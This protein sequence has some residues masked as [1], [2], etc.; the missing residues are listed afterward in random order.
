MTVGMKHKALP[1]ADLLEDFYDNLQRAYLSLRRAFKLRSSGGMSQDDLAVMLQ[2]DKG[3]IS[4]RLNGEANLTLKT[5]SYLASALACRLL[6]IFQPYEDIAAS[7]Y[8]FGYQLKTP[9]SAQPAALFIQSSAGSSASN[10][11]QFVHG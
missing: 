1:K 10:T 8:Y 2:T 11:T 7:N 3:L 4:K 9:S 5:L 6:I